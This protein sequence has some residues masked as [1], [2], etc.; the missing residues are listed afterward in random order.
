MKTTRQELYRQGDVMFCAIHKLPAGKSTK[1]DNGTVAYG[2]VTGHSHRL[3]D[4]ATA[5]VI[6]I[7]NGLFVHVSEEGIS[8]EGN[9]GATFVHEEHGPISLPPGDYRVQ[10]QREYS[11]QE[12]RSVVD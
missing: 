6:E 5:E 9:P 8:I 11:P 12:I 7:E 1:R 10:I 3:A 4:L 2:E